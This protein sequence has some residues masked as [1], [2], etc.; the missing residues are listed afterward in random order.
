MPFHKYTFRTTT[1]HNVAGKFKHVSIYLYR[2]DKKASNSEN[3]KRRREH[4]LFN[5]I[6]WFREAMNEKN[7]RHLPFLC[8]VH[9]YSIS[10]DP[11]MFYVTRDFLFLFYNSCFRCIID[12]C[13]HRQWIFDA[14]DIYLRRKFNPTDMCRNAIWKWTWAFFL[15]HITLFSPLQ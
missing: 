4:I 10:M 14:G 2:F 12:R 7:K 13:E 11:S 5:Q 1:L 3:K 9:R 8:Y 6:P 15:G